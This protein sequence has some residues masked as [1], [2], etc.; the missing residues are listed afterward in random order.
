MYKNGPQRN[1]KYNNGI[2]QNNT[3]Q[4]DLLDYDSAVKNMTLYSDDGRSTECRGAK[5]VADCIF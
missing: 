5:T 3:W 1:D 4:N 2:L